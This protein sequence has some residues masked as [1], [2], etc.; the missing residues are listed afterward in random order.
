L[1]V[2]V[3]VCVCGCICINS[4]C[5]LGDYI[6]DRILCLMFSLL[7]RVFFCF[8]F[9][10]V[11]GFFGC[12]LLTQHS[13]FNSCYR[14]VVYK[15]YVLLLWW[16][17][18]DDDDDDDDSDRLVATDRRRT[19]IFTFWN[20]PLTPSLLR[21]VNF[22]GWKMQGRDWKQCIFRSFNSSTFK[23]MRFDENP[24]TCL[25]ENVLGR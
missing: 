15:I 13:E 18:D 19:P 11:C 24:F 14:V 25:C 5:L 17:C 2:C 23:A 10:C 8:C 1:C 21:P 12:K 4:N 7:K 9:L 3:C 16:W 6:F 22:P 20:L